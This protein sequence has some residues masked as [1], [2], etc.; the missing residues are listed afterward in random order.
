MDVVDSFFCANA[1]CGCAEKGMFAFRRVLH[2]AHVDVHNFV[3]K[4]E[5]RRDIIL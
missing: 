1:V 2:D 5:D 3:L 4:C